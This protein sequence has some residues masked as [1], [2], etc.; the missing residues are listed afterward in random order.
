MRGG[1]RLI[2]TVDPAAH[3]LFHRAVERLAIGVRRLAFV[4]PDDEMHA[5]QRTFG[6]ER[7]EGAHAAFEGGGEIIADR[8]PDP[9]VVTFTR[10][11]DEDR[12]EAVEAVAPRQ[13][14]HARPLVELQDGEREL[15][16]R[17]FVDLEQLVARIGFQHVDQRLAGMAVLIEAGAADDVVDL[18]PQIRNGA[19]RARI[20][21]GGEQAAEPAFADEPAVGIEALDPDVIEMHAPVHARAHRRLGDDE[22]SAALRGIRGFRG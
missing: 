3:D 12:D 8:R 6:K 1:D 17:V 4:A 16:E 11:I 20:G 22:Q 9:A 7:I 2:E 5:H 18:A 14:A 10:D 13:H 19:G 21:G 15:V